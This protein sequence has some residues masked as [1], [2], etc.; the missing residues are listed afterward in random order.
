MGKS[1]KSLSLFDF[2]Q[3]FMTDNQCFAY[4]AAEK[5]KNGY[6][7]TR[8]GHSLYCQRNTFYSRQGTRCKHTTS[9]TSGT[10]FHK[11]KERKELIMF[12]I[13]KRDKGISRLYG[14]VIDK[15]DAKNLGKFM[16]EKIK[17]KA[18]VKTDKYLGYKSLK[19]EFEN[20][21]QLSSGEKGGNFP[22]IHRAIML[23][24]AWLIMLLI[25]RHI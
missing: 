3:Q 4:L 10:F 14:K 21:T 24:K 5:W 23:F 2:Q 20:M 25:Y 15:A 12:V 8:C 11:I 19:N 1:Y 22:E 18:N 13:E 16:R 9:P 7:C 6:V 17:K